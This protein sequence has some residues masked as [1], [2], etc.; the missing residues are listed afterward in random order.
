MIPDVAICDPE[1]T[2]G[3]PA[4]LTAATGMDA[5]SHCIETFCSPKFN[6]VADAIALDGL[7]RA[8]TH[9]R[10]AVED[11]SNIQARSEM[12]MASMQGAL[13]FQKGLGMI[14]SLSHP[15]GAI[16]KRL[17]HGTLT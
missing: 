8:V 5:I 16:P 9:L 6:P 4:D 11:G 10:I 12:M 13:A 14:H 7:Q 17:H 3:L 2:L 1:L 15:L